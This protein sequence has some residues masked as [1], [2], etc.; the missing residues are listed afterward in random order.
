MSIII[1]GCISDIIAFINTVGF[2]DWL[3]ASASILPIPYLNTPK[4]PHI[5]PKIDNATKETIVHTTDITIRLDVRL[6][7]VARHTDAGT[8]CCTYDRQVLN[9][10]NVIF[11]VLI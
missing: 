11:R 3:S 7:T 5:A 1:Y 9:D 6:I 10:P 4:M 2:A 8:S